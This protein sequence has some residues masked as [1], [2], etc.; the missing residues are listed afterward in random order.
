LQFVKDP[1]TRFDLALECGDI[2][3][4]LEMAKVIEKPEYWK[5]L[6]IEALRQGNQEMVEYV[7]QRT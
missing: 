5:K 3:A 2:E 1:K 7:Y 4:A 6:G